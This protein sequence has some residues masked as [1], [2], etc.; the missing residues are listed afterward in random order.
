[1]DSACKTNNK[2]PIKV[3]L[4]MFSPFLFYDKLQQNND[5]IVHMHITNY[6]QAC[7][8]F[9]KEILNH[10]QSLEIILFDSQV[11]SMEC[12]RP[13]TLSVKNFHFT[14]FPDRDIPTNTEHM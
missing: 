3:E 4:I 5:Y 2:S 12:L 9:E 1:M 14:V 13:R 7:Y 8:G 6:L 10:G 11:I